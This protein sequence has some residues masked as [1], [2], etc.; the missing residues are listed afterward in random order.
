MKGIEQEKYLSGSYQRGRRMLRA[1][2][3]K[4]LR[5]APV[6]LRQEMAARRARV[7]GVSFYT[8]VRFWIEISIMSL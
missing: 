2:L 7:K 5:N 1:V 4:A 8:K 3:V 6:S